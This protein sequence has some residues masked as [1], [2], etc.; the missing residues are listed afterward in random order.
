M[1]G[2]V[3]ILQRAAALRRALA[4]PSASRIVIRPRPGW[5]LIDF[6]DVWRFRDLLWLLMLRDLRV[7]YK[8]TLLGVSW[9][10][11]QPLLTTGVFTLLL[12]QFAMS[13]EQTGGLPYPLFVFSGLVAWNFFASA[14][15]RAANSVVGSQSL[16]TKVYFPR[17][18]LPLAAVGVCLV[19]TLISAGVMMGLLGW[20]GIYPG[21]HLLLLPLFTLLIA[22][23]AAGIGSLAA[24]LAG[25][26]RDVLQ[27]LAFGLQIWFYLTPVLYPA[28]LVPPR[29]HWVVELNPMVTIIDGFRSSLTMAAEPPSAARLLVS[30]LL[31][32]LVLVVCLLGFR[33]LERRLADLI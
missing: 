29:W 7:R 1:R 24:G 23:L 13:R 17:I 21:P 27:F 6:L 9:I 2:T 18:I 15:S 3:A 16:I 19:D 31:P 4:T 30:F 32:P 5:Q 11:I 28:S 25:L 12:G 22:V 14:V 10:V 26:Y 8:Q 20:Y 33:R